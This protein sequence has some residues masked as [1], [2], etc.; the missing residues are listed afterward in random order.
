M[1]FVI[2]EGEG[3]S[4]MRISGR[5]DTLNSEKFE[6]RIQELLPLTKD[7][8]IDCAN[9]EYISSSGLRGLRCFLFLLKS[10]QESKHTVTLVNMTAPIKEVFDITGF[11]SMFAIE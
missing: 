4:G 2:T 10:A 6:K 7:L 5:L 1:E 8:E 11:S 9:L 3:K